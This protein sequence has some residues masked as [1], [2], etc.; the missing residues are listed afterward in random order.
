MV[1]RSLEKMML[2][3]IGLTAAVIVGVPVLM[4]AIDTLGATSQLERARQVAQS[5]HNGAAKV[6]EGVVNSTVIEVTLP[7]G[8]TMSADNT[9]LTIVFENEGVETSSWSETYDYAI[10]LSGP[11][12]PGTYIVNIT[13]VSGTIEVSFT[14]VV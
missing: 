5:I 3:A 7:E 14:S 8:V 10:V 9:T 2:I 4:Y 13:K 6:D 12:G 11:S 1:S